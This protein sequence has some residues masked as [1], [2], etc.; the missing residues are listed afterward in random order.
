ME[1]KNRLDKV[2]YGMLTVSEI[3]SLLFLLIAVVLIVF[4]IYVG[5]DTSGGSWV[6]LAVAVMGTVFLPII[7]SWIA[8][9]V[10]YIVGMCKYKKGKMHAARMLGIINCAV[11]MIGNMYLLWLD[12]RDFTKWRIR[13]ASLVGPALV[14]VYMAIILLLLIFSLN[15]E[16]ADQ[17]C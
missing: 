17:A 8:H 4:C 15:K 13:W 2:A 14:V 9:I 1:Q 3:I 7:I 5:I 12:G 6:L 11:L 10:L 16:R